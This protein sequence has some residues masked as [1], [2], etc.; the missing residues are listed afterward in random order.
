MTEKK[1]RR[2]GVLPVILCIVLIGLA[3]AAYKQFIAGTLT[4]DYQK[5]MTV[6]GNKL[7]IKGEISHSQR[8]VSRT[9]IA[10]GKLLVYECLPSFWKKGR[11]FFVEYDLSQGE[12]TVNGD[13]VK[14]DGF[15]IS[16]KALALYDARNPY[17]GDMPGNNRIAEILE[18]SKSLGNYKNALQTA[19]EPFGWTLNF[20]EEVSVA[21]RISFD[22]RM[23]SYGIALMAMVD[24]CDEVSW[25]YKSGDET[26]T[27]TRT[28]ED[29]N[30]KA[31]KDIKT[32]SESPEKV[33][34]LMELL[35]LN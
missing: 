31:G 20:E 19:K 16:K 33:Q 30:K 24:N 27:V 6:N 28:A 17:I 11:T 22:S 9:K 29:G 8:A 15:I 4:E 3:I 7:K 34:E 2:Y 35:E 12:L 14:S 13:V 1:K 5:E 32:L 10:G 21:D 18:I 25:T 26:V 23:E